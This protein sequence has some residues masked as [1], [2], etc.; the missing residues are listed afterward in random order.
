MKMTKN[1]IVSIAAGLLLMICALPAKAQ[2][3]PQ[4]TQYMFN[5]LFINPAY[6]GSRDNLSGTMLWREQW[7]GLDGAPSTKTLTV[8][9]PFAN[10]KIGAGITLMRESIGVSQRTSFSAVGAYRIPMDKNTLSFGLQLGLVNL[11]EDLMN[12]NLLTDNQFQVNTGNVTAP[13][14]GAGMYYNTPKWYV[15]LS[16]PRLLQNRLD[17][18]SGAAKVENRL[19]GKDLHYFV[20][21]GSVFGISPGVKLR[22][23]VM[24]KAVSGAPMQVDLSCN[25]LFN[26]FIW[27]GLAY[28]TGDAVSALLGVQIT[29]QLRLGY[30][31][32]FTTSELQ[33]FN[34][35]SHEF[36]L[37]F[38]FGFDKNKVV[39]PRYF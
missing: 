33:D 37:G 20:T 11:S 38:D 18:T 32:D 25:A 34:S 17:V 36:M 15:G 12:L 29:K 14:V 27:G 7:V 6:A 24:L 9:A 22:P 10:K 2:F 19:N 31:Y 1:N 16:V 35:G 28:R 21:A 39:T 13:N 23:N 4:F 3:D 5:E 30:A 8:H 26:D